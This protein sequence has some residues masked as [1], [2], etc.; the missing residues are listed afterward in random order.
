MLAGRPPRSTAVF[1][2]I[3]TVSVILYDCQSLMK[4]RREPAL[5][6]TVRQTPKHLLGSN[7]DLACLVNEDGLPKV[8]SRIDQCQTI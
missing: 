8:N 7:A 2:V 5:A 6:V 4:A 1:R 3:D